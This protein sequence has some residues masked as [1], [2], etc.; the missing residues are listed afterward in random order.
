MK[1]VADKEVLRQAR[2]DSQSSADHP[3]RLGIWA[4][5][6]WVLLLWVSPWAV[7]KVSAVVGVLSQGSSGKGSSSKLT[8]VAVG[9]FSFSQGLSSLLA[10]DQGP[11]SFPCQVGLSRGQLTTWPLAS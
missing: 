9:R 10:V 5:L 6:S 11:P 2:A 4:Q 8:Q 3:Q 7:I 1:E